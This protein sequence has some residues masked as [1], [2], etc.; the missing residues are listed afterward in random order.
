MLRQTVPYASGGNREGTIADGGQS[1]VYDEQ[2]AMMRISAAV[3][4]PLNLPGA[5]A[6]RRG[7]TVPSRADTSTPEQRA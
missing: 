1:Y 6:H 7:E 5:G 4:G 3:S 2:S